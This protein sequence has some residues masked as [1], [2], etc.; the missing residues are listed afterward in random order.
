MSTSIL[1]KR[2]SFRITP[3]L[4]L[5]EDRVVP[6]TFTVNS[7]LDTPVV[8]KLDLREAVALANSTPGADTI[9]FDVSLT[10]QT[11]K[12]NS[13][14]DITDT[15]QING[16]G[17]GSNPNLLAISGQNST[18]L[19]ENHATSL[20]INGLTLENGAA[21]S[22]NFAP[23]GGGDGGAI[24]NDAGFLSLS[25]D[26]FVNNMASNRG[27]AVFNLYGAVFST[28]STYTG[29]SSSAHGGAIYN[30][31]LLVSNANSFIANTAAVAGGAV[32]N[33]SSVLALQ[34]VTATSANDF[35]SGNHAQAGA[36][37]EVANGATATVNADV[38]SSNV[39]NVEG[40]AIRVDAS[41]V[42][43]SK[44]T[45]ANSVLT[46]NAAQQAGGAIKSDGTLSVSN[47]SLTFNT[48]VQGGAIYALNSKTT[49]TANTVNNNSAPQIVLA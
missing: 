47:S 34:G 26:R 2:R 7:A 42:P 21:V 45:I 17:G 35:F 16:L 9:N 44:L 25:N 5:M 1:R 10:G 46:N 33:A 15:L 48:A 40:G 19:F 4:E 24:Q 3:R 27:G 18:R 36:A 31:G 30:S 38:F 41:L 20:T 22:S 37:L 39:A 8:G 6:S 49:L 28:S 14:L 11:I 23:G 29:N 43:T 32:E 13:Q 12:L